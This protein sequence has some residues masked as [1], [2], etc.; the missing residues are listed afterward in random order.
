[1]KRLRRISARRTA[2]AAGLLATLAA[3]PAVADEP[4]AADDGANGQWI[5]GVVLTSFAGAAFVAG[6]VTGALALHKHQQLTALCPER[7]CEPPLHGEVDQFNAL[8][9]AATASIAVAGAALVGGLSLMLT[10]PNSDSADG[11]HADVRVTLAP[12]ALVVEGAF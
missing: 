7:S 9:I 8:R 4:S 10:A 5:A 11:S 6:T 12:G 2:A 3:Y 1:M